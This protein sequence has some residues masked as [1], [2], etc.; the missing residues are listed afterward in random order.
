MKK[1]FSTTSNIFF[2]LP[3]Y[4]SFIYE[5]WWHL[6]IIFFVLFFGFLY[7]TSSRKKYYHFDV[8]FAWLLIITNLH[9]VYM[10]GFFDTYFLIALF[11]V[12]IAL[13]SYYYGQEKYS[14]DLFHGIWHISSA[15]ITTLCILTFV[16]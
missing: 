13:Y 9:S 6:F 10:G 5:R 3:M 7:H 2:L 1:N 8:V 15:I 11:F 16:F 12:T 4:F 14:Y